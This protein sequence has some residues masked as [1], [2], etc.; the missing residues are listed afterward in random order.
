V[1]ELID[2]AD[3]NGVRSVLLEA[4]GTPRNSCDQYGCENE[5]GRN[6]QRL[7]PRDAERGVR[8]GVIRLATGAVE[9][10][11]DALNDVAVAGYTPD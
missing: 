3:R 11:T 2:R 1:G 8:T 5:L 6:C 9:V 10:A 7:R 4:L